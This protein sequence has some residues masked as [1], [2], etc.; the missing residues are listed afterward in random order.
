MRWY[1]YQ[2]RCLWLS[3]FA[4]SVQAASKASQEWIEAGGFVVSH[5]A[6]IEFAPMRT[7]NAL[8][9][10]FLMICLCFM[11]I[12]SLL[13]SLIFLNIVPAVSVRVSFHL[14]LQF[15]TYP[16]VT[17]YSENSA[18][19]MRYPRQKSIHWMDCKVVPAI[20]FQSR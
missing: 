14:L 13:L 10:K 5:A 12:H 17:T 16:V 3:S 20:F 9:R 1:C 8:K 6:S 2:G 4:L 15:S 19:N 7:G 11:V 18:V